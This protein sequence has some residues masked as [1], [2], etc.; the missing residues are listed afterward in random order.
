MV[1]H[2]RDVHKSYRTGSAHEEV[3][4]ATRIDRPSS[5]EV[6]SESM[7]GGKGAFERE[8]SLSA[9]VT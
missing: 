6:V 3:V 7:P 8:G 4:R 2:A 1:L 5:G 9:C